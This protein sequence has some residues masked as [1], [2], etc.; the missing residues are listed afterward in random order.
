MEAML[1]RY[2]PLLERYELALQANGF[3]KQRRAIKKG[4]G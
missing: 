4:L 3:L 2:E 1:K